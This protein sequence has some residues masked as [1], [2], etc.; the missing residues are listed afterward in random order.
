[1]LE[2]VKNAR[3]EGSGLMF[4]DP[5]Q[6]GNALMLKILKKVSEQD[7]ACGE[8]LRELLWFAIYEDLGKMLKTSLNGETLIEALNRVM[9]RYGKLPLPK[10]IYRLIRLAFLGFIRPLPGESAKKHT[11]PGGRF[12][13]SQHDLE[14]DAQVATE[15]WLS[16]CENWGI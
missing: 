1:M 3:F 11:P 4:N 9:K 10:H 8:V 6:Y 13:A 14:N 12:S 15:K 2:T 7:R 5:A 16:L